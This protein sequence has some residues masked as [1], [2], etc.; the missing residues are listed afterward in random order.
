MATVS[1]LKVIAKAEGVKVRFPQ[2]ISDEDA[3]ALLEA[4]RAEREQGETEI[5]KPDGA[6]DCFGEFVVEGAAKCRR[7]SVSK[8][9]KAV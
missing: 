6:P 8:D 5:V 2:G 1:E 4:K 7:C 9:C 3:L